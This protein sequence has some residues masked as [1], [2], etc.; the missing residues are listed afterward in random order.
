M[1]KTIVSIFKKINQILHAVATVIASVI[2]VFCVVV[3]G[4]YLYGIRPYIVQ[5]GSMEPEIET[6]SICFVNQRVPFE[7]IKE[8][9]IIAFQ[10]G[11]ML[12]TH[13]A[14]EV[15]ESEIVTKGDAN[16]VADAAVVTKDN[17]V[18]KT[19]YYIRKI[20]LIIMLLKT[21]RGMI[22]SIT[23]AV[24]IMLSGFLNYDEKNENY[25]SEKDI[26]E[27]SAGSTEKRGD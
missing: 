3:A 18:G 14:I 19:I 13:R 24:V 2:L 15:K 5:T 27:E 8:N 7:E 11:S 16:N 26:S 23:A 6:G 17:Y 22:I 10:T 1:K 21:R 9:D 12:V 25:K 20:G 4:M